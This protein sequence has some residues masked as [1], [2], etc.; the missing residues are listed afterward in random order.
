MPESPEDKKWEAESDANTLAEAG[1]IINDDAR[2]NAARKAAKNLAK[3]AK[4]RFEAMI[5]IANKGGKV[6]GM[7]VLRDDTGNA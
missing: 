5:K 1:V 6:E 7:K 4:V 2:L 3:D